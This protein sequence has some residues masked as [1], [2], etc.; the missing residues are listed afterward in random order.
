MV[1]ISSS[2][3]SSLSHIIKYDLDMFSV[4][5]ATFAFMHAVTQRNLQCL[6]RSFASQINEY[7][8]LVHWISQLLLPHNSLPQVQ[9]N[10]LFS[11]FYLFGRHVQSDLQ[12]N[13]AIFFSSTQ[14]SLEIKH[15][16]LALLKTC[17]NI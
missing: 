16:T 10:Y 6:Y 2:L 9:S 12:C 15:M 1:F 8:D 5:F 7:F 11:T 13:Q 17:P 4:T 14:I 3:Q